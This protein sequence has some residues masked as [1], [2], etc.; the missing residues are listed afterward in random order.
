MSAVDVTHVHQDIH[1]QTL[2]PTKEYYKLDA[3]KLG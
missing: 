3:E 1:S 2:P